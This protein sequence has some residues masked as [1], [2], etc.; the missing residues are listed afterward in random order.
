MSERGRSERGEHEEQEEST[1][2][3]EYA[4]RLPQPGSRCVRDSRL[5]DDPYLH[6]LEISLWTAGLIEETILDHHGFAR[7]EPGPVT[8]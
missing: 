3:E 7:F 8:L 2:G 6:G 4:P 1:D 5:G